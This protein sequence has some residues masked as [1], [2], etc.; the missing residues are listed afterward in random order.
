[1]CFVYVFLF[2]PYLFFMYFAI[3]TAAFIAGAI[4]TAGIPGC[5][6]LGL[7]KVLA[8]R[9]DDLPP[10]PWFP[11]RPDPGEP[12]EIGYFYG[13]RSPAFA[14]IRHVSAVAYRLAKDFA[15]RGSQAL[16]SGFTGSTSRRRR[17]SGKLLTVP[18]AIGGAA[19]L[20][21]GIAFGAAGFIAIAIVHAVVATT[22][23]AC[24][25]AVGLALR[26]I[27]T[28][29]LRIKNIRM[30]CPHCFERVPYPAYKCNGDGCGRMHEDVRPG[31]YGIFSRRCLCGNSLP[32]LLL[33]GS[34][35]S[36]KLSAYCPYQGCRK[37]LEHRPGE[38]QEI[39]LPFFGA[40]GAGKTRLMYGI[41]T[42][43]RSAAGLTA[44]FADAATNAE[45]DAVRTLLAPGE[46]PAKTARALPRGQIMR[47]TSSGGTRLLQLYDS[48]GERFYSTA[49][50][51]ELG[52]LNKAK[53]FVL[54]I[55]PLSIDYLWLGLPADRQAALTAIRSDAPSP[56]LAF[57]QTHQQMEAMGVRLKKARLAVVFSRADLLDDPGDQSAD[58]WAAD[59]LGLGNLIRSARLQFGQAAFFRTAS[60]LESSGELHP[61]VEELTRWLVSNDG[62][63][64]PERDTWMARS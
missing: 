41:V 13:F 45:L 52:Y 42:L 27:D 39:V 20:G 50:T 46:A 38:A 57:Q 5:Y 54:V 18:L 11:T 33:L 36:A 40:A 3:P 1:M 28:G 10:A 8:I 4:Y 29:L 15:G 19:G 30:T 63:S 55:D 62:I 31:R 32:T 56:E 58:A 2:I 7:F 23:F 60:V 24:I 12:A 17:S 53:T 6:V 43:L 25:A 44:E 16:K 26:L 64:I 22:V 14:E 9:P 21:V 48:A 47:V 34:A 59:T 37:P 61:S 51:D 49:D 35:T